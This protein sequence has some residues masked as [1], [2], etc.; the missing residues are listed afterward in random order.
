MNGLIQ[1]PV[2]GYQTMNVKEGDTLKT[3]HN[4]NGMWGEQLWH[5]GEWAIYKPAL[6]D[7]GLGARYYDHVLI[8]SRI[9]REKRVVHR[10]PR[11]ICEDIKWREGADMESVQPYFDTEEVELVCHTQIYPSKA[12]QCPTCNVKIPD[13]A[14]AVWKL[15]NWDKLSEEK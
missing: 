10:E 12:V 2:T 14:I 11:F 15:L 5:K 8:H 3:Y 7:R 13:E 1:R 4:V 9:W 6:G